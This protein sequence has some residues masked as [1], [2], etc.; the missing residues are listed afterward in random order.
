MDYG[1]YNASFLRLVCSAR[2]VDACTSTRVDV[3]GVRQP[4][5]RARPPQRDV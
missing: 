5:P 2:H 1:V 4:E 3:H